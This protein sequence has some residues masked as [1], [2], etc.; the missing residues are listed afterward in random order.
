MAFG[1][2]RHLLNPLWFCDAP[3]DCEAVVAVRHHWHMGKGPVDGLILHWV[4][5]LK[6]GTKYEYQS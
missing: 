2:K 5:A 3:F 1:G 6:V 4:H